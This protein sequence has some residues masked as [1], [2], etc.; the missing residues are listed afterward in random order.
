MQNLVTWDVVSW[1]VI[2]S[3]IF[4][5]RLT[6]VSLATVRHILVFK[7][8]RKIVPLLAFVEVTIWLVAITQVMQN[9]NNVACFLAW[10]A[11][12]SA[13]TYLG[14]IIEEKLA[15]GHQLVRVIAHGETKDLIDVVREKGY[16]HTTMKAAGNRG[17]VDVFLIVSERK[18]LKSLLEGLNALTPKP[19]Y[20]IE[21]VRSV[22][23]SVFHASTSPGRMAIE[24]TLKKK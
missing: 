14:M 10:A 22:G 19:F 8:Q 7:G 4:L 9:L 24:G 6:D 16:G 15:L 18:R 11:G 5:A 1:V 3:L 2:P 12:F 23:A 21:D 13:G 17:S 20:T